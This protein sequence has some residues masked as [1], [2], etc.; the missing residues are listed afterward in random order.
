MR[1]KT[2]VL[3]T[4][5]QLC[6]WCGHPAGGHMYVEEGGEQVPV[7]PPNPL[8]HVMLL[9][10]AG[11]RVIHHVGEGTELPGCARLDPMF[12]YLVSNHMPSIIE[13]LATIR[14]RGEQRVVDL[15]PKPKRL[16]VRR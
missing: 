3:N 8:S 1:A 7:G 11:L 5:Q 14:A 13:A 2:H 16:K 15:H 9:K 12:T 10:K 4:A 6:A